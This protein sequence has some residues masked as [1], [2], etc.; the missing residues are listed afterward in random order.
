MDY[1]TFDELRV[2]GCPNELLI[3]YVMMPKAWIDKLLKESK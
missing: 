1:Y 2:F 3:Q